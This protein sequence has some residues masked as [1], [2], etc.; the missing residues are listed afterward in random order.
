MYTKI[1]Q[2]HK[3]NFNRHRDRLWRLDKISLAAFALNW[4]IP[5]SIEL[6][7][8][9]HITYLPYYHCWLTAPLWLLLIL[10]PLSPLPVSDHHWPFFCHA[11]HIAVAVALR[12]LAMPRLLLL[13]W[14]S[15]QQVAR[16]SVLEGSVLCCSLD[17]ILDGQFIQ[18]HEC[19]SLCNFRHVIQS[20]PETKLF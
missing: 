15:H 8:L 3:Y 11:T 7:T 6:K 1:N 20:K 13:L 18:R 10:S 2:L 19:F 12:M 9:K 4:S 14:D 5:E 16:I 17:E